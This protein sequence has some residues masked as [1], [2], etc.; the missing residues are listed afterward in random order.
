MTSAQWTIRLTKSALLHASLIFGAL[1]S[2]FPFYYMF[3]LSSRRVEEMFRW[4]PPLWFGSTFMANVAKLNNTPL[5]DYWRSMW[6]SAYIASS[7]T[8]LVLFFC[9]MAGY[10]FAMYD[11]PLKRQLFAFMLVTMMIPGIVGLIP[12]FIMMKWFGWYNT[13][14]ALIVPGVASAFGIF[15]MRQYIG[16]AVPPD[17]LDAARIDGCPEWQIF[18]RVVA[19]IL[20]PAYGAL[21]IMTFLGSW[22]SFMGPMLLLQDIDKL[23]LPLVISKLRGAPAYGFDY[24]AIM[25]S[26]TLA[27]V[28]ILVVFL[29]ASRKFMSGLT[30]GAIKE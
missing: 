11:F 22:N 12:W 29:L 9:S 21:G 18:W 2:A 23:T 7:H 5:V 16:S 25:M 28:P 4:P 19:P 8:L 1:L 14:T 3:V 6:N 15:W 30:A 13:H 24:A 27:T 10:A 20:T 17:L 26:T